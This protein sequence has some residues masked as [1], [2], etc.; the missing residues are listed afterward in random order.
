MM[1]TGKSPVMR[2]WHSTAVLLVAML[3][4][5]ILPALASAAVTSDIY[6]NETGW[7]HD[8][9]DFN[10][11]STQIQAAIDNAT[12]GETIYV[13]NGSYTENYWSDY[14]G[15]DTNDDGLGDNLLP[16]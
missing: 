9:G 12:A 6:V 4:L 10:A 7:W 1:E 16:Y 8:G 3:A 5:C 14:A 2:R 13:Y 11:S 15:D